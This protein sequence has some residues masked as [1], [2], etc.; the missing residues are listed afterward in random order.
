MDRSP[1]IRNNLLN[2]NIL[3]N[4]IHS[5]TTGQ[6]RQLL[7]EESRKLMENGS[8]VKFELLDGA[9]LTGVDDV[10]IS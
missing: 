9:Y 3:S 10:I 5:P 1:S 6:S 7:R 4:Y 8:T 2:P